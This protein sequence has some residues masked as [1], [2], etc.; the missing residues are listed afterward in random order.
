MEGLFTEVCA[1]DAEEE[2]ITVKWVDKSFPCIMGDKV[3]LARGKYFLTNESL[4]KRLRI[5]VEALEK[6]QFDSFYTVSIITPALEKIRAK[7]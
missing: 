4:E 5:A 2:T 3:I 6:L 1:G 7:Q